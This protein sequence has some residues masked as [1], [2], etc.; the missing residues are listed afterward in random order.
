MAKVKRVRD[1]QQEYKNRIARAEQLAKL[2]GQTI[3][4]SVARGHARANVE[5]DISL[6]HL[7]KQGVTT[8]STSSTINKTKAVITRMAKGESLTAATK[9]EK[10]TPKAF[11][12]YAASID[13]IKTTTHGNTKRITIKKRYWTV[14]T[15]DGVIHDDV[16]MDALNAS[17]ISK[18]WHTVSESTA[19]DHNHLKIFTP[20][21]VT[22]LFGNEYALLLDYD[23][24]LALNMVA[25]DANGDKRPI[26]NPKYS[27]DG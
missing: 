25:D 7:R 15:S 23:E 12:K 11:K 3:S 5:A 1:Y 21:T 13:G 20:N 9:A 27:T 2:S 14:V 24:L 26:N 6:K 18:Y 19:S 10:I 8:S 4:K 16:L 17:T 22:D